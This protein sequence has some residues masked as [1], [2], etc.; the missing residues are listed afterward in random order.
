MDDIE[1]GLV[2]GSR[3]LE[4][5]GLMVEPSATCLGHQSGGRRV[6]HGRDLARPRAVTAKAA[7]EVAM[8]A[9]ARVIEIITHEDGP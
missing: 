2:N 9:E 4:A 8:N 7:K 6:A 1:L 3:D 5:E